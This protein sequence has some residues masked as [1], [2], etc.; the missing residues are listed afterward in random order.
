MRDTAAHRSSDYSVRTNPADVYIILQINEHIWVQT[1]DTDC[2]L[3]YTSTDSEQHKPFHHQ[4]NNQQNQTQVNMIKTTQEVPQ[5]IETQKLTG[6]DTKEESLGWN[7]RRR[8]QQ[9]NE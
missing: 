8:V 4:D 6:H 5:E 3:T 7:T 9:N 2:S 1:T